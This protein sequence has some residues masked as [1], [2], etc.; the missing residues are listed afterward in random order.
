[1]QTLINFIQSWLNES[2]KPFIELYD[3]LRRS[4]PAW[5]PFL[6]LHSHLRRLLLSNI[7]STDSLRAGEKEHSFRSSF[8]SMFSSR[9]L[10]EYAIEPA[11]RKIYRSRAMYRVKVSAWSTGRSSASTVLKLNRRK[12]LVMRRIEVSGKPWL[13]DHI[14]HLLYSQ[15]LA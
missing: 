3:Y 12:R 5:S 4:L 1:M 15:T 13:S 9:R 6:T 7:A 14:H 10:I 8:S 11:N 2:N